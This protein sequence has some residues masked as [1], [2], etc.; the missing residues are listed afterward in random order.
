M[1]FRSVSSAQHNSTQEGYSWKNL[2]LAPCLGG[3]RWSRGVGNPAMESGRESER[4]RVCLR[5]SSWSR[6]ALII[7]GAAVGSLYTQNHSPNDIL[8]SYIPLLLNH[9]FMVKGLF[10]QAQ[11]CSVCSVYY[12]FHVSDEETD[13][14]KQCVCLKASHPK[15]IESPDSLNM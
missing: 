5:S 11:G 7:T 12:S 8:A 4:P 14:E 9:D 15:Q 2:R 1:C 10:H 13:T 3:C 6:A